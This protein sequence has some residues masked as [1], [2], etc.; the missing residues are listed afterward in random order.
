M[1]PLPCTVPGRP[2]PRLSPRWLSAGKVD[3][4]VEAWRPALDPAQ[5]QMLHG[6]EADCAARN[7][8][9]HGRRDLLDLERLHQPQ[10]LHELAL[11]LLTH[12]RFQKTPQRHELFRQLPAGQRRS[13]VES[14]DL[15]L[16]QGEVMQRIEHEVLALAGT[17]IRAITSAP[18]EMTTSWT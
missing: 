6:V 7:G 15:L 10:A 11:T 9:T 2:G 18:H 12:P 3:R 8:I 1:T 4:H 17:R 5:H 13:L 16:D 14:I